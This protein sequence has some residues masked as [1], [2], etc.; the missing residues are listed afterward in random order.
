MRDFGALGDSVTTDTA[1]IQQAI[2]ACA[3]QGGGT[4][5]VPPGNYLVGRI[6]LRD[7]ITLWLEAGSV[8]LA[9]TN[10]QD[11]QIVDVYAKCTNSTR[12]YG[13]LVAQ[14]ATNITIKGK[15]RIDG[16]DKAFWTPKETIGEGWNSTPPRY[17]PKDWRPMLLLLEE[18]HNVEITG[19]TIS[20]SPVYA[21]W[22]IDCNYVSL[23][24]LLIQNDF[25]GPNSDGFHISSC[26]YV[27]IH[28]CHFVTGD[29]SIAI[30]SNGQQN[31]QHFTISNCTFNTSVNVFRI[32]TGLDPWV[33]EAVYSEIRN[34]TV[35][36]CSVVNAAGVLNV[37]AEDGCIEGITISNMTI[38]MEQE[39]T[40]IFLMASNGKIRNIH[41]QH[42][43]V[44]GNGACTIIGLP[45][46]EIT[47]VALS[48]MNFNLTAKK[49]MYGYDIPDP[50]PSYAQHHFAP[51]GFYI[52]NAAN[53][54]LT[55]VHMKQCTSTVPNDW[56]TIKCMKVDHL[57]VEGLVY[58]SETVF[59][60]TPLVYLADVHTAQFT[61]CR[62]LTKT[63]TF[64]HVTGILP[65]QLYFTGSMLEQVTTL[66]K[67]DPNTTYNLKS[68]PNHI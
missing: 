15:G 14:G 29:D 42:W 44:N 46:D 24:H 31:A 47:D 36:N 35:T 43:Y 56:Y 33:R 18:C 9:S 40:A 48:H 11:Y 58:E 62:T 13:L 6:E 20:A 5:Y 32:Y 25:Y 26:R 45:E 21:G 16:Q 50:I 23:H 12:Y 30:D 3:Y 59:T 49:K 57:Y 10:Q 63:E 68:T 8:L 64:V 4:V 60:E 54:S 52:R 51:Y 38:G 66:C 67:A 41:L 39:G 1:A 34:I 55:Q 27:N 7:H 37:T 17:D 2:D 22:L 53:V 61:N 28:A 19:I 65:T